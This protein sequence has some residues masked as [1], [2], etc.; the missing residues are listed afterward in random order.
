MHQQSDT[1]QTADFVIHRGLCL[2]KAVKADK[3]RCKGKYMYTDNY[4]FAEKVVQITS[5]HPYVHEFCK[6]Y[7]TDTAPELIVTTTSEDI[8]K[9][10]VYTENMFVK[11]PHSRFEPTDGALEASAVYRG[12]AEQMIAFDTLLF[13]GSVVAVDGAAYIFTAKSGTGKSTHAKLWC[14]L[15]G[16]RAVMVNDDKPLIRVSEKVTAFG[17]PYNGKHRRGNNI[18]APVKCVCI[19]ERDKYNHIEPV[20]EKDAFGI[21]MQ[22]TYRP[23]DAALTAKVIPLIDKMA[24]GVKL[25]RLG[26]NMDIEA[27]KIAFDGMNKF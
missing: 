22:Q 6:D 4:I 11:D 7:R 19:L 20:T 5:V 3:I 15:F 18:S 17:T 12:I 9:E 16:E 21:L 25:F 24:K 23:Y 13:H 1:G 2:C 8:E 14:E 27:A 10:R 26:C